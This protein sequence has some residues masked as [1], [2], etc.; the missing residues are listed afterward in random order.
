MGNPY[1]N[2]IGGKANHKTKKVGVKAKT[3]SSS[4]PQKDFVP[5]KSGYKNYTISVSNDFGEFLHEQVIHGGAV[6]RKMTDI[7]VTF[8]N[9][10][11]G[12]L[13]NEWKEQRNG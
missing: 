9:E 4:K 6:K 1:L 2:K 5:G 8:L 13:Y 7:L 11:Y 3:L 12:D 10:E